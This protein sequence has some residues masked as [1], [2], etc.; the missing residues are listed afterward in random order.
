VNRRHRA[1]IADLVDADPVWA[2]G[3]GPGFDARSSGSEVRG[4]G[5]G[6]R[7]VAYGLVVLLGWDGTPVSWYFGVRRGALAVAESISRGIFVCCVQGR[8]LGNN[9]IPQ[10]VNVFI[11]LVTMFRECSTFVVYIYIYIYWG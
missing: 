9:S 11:N 1:R 7:D 4:A 8:G 5:P 10:V 6:R 3:G 2:R